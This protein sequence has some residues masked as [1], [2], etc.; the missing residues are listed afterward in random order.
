MDWVIGADGTTD[1]IADSD[2]VIITLEET[3][4]GSLDSA[5]VTVTAAYEL[6]ND[7][8][9]YAGVQT[10]TSASIYP[11]EARDDVRLPEASDEGVITTPFAAAVSINR[12]PWL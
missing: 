7:Y 2:D 6:T 9:Q 4:A 3:V 1:N 11:E 12:V 8:K 5:K 10:D